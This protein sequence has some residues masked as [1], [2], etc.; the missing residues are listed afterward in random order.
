MVLSTQSLIS[1]SLRGPAPI[2]HAVL[3]GEPFTG[4][5]LQTLDP[6]AFDHGTVLAQTPA[7]GIPIPQ[8]ISLADMTHELAVQGGEMLVQGLRD[9]VHVPPLQDVGWMVPE[10][11]GLVHAPKVTKADMQID[12]HTARAEDVPRKLRVFGSLWTQGV[13]ASGKN[14]GSKKRVLFTAAKQA[15]DEIVEASTSNGAINFVSD[16]GVEKRVSV[17]V[18][19]NSG[20]VYCRDDG[21]SWIGIVKAKVDGSAERDASS[22]LRPFLQ[23]TQN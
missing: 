18:D 17:K 21:G 2:H 15:E 8:D 16:T 12:W 11:D 3:R 6:T 22:A 23:E 20:V 7:P 10:G 9:G 14:A 19:A 4:V 5:S 1:Y 13:V